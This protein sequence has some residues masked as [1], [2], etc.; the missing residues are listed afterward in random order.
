MFVIY[1][2]LLNQIEL[3]VMF[4]NLINY[5]DNILQKF[6]AEELEKIAENCFTSKTKNY[7]LLAKITPF[8]GCGQICPLLHAVSI[9]EVKAIEVMIDNYR[10]DLIVALREYDVLGHLWFSSNIEKPKD[11]KTEQ[12]DNLYNLTYMISDYEINS[13]RNIKRS[14][15]TTDE[16]LLQINQTRDF[17]DNSFQII[18]EIDK[19]SSKIKQSD[20]TSHVDMTIE[21]KKSK[22]AKV[23][24]ILFKYTKEI[25]QKDLENYAKVASLAEFN[26]LILERQVDLSKMSLKLPLYDILTQEPLLKG[27]NYNSVEDILLMHSYS[28]NKTQAEIRKVYSNLLNV[29][30]VASDIMHFTALNLLKGDDLKIVFDSPIPGAYAPMENI[31]MI[32][33][34]NGKFT[35]ESIVIHELGHYAVSGLYPYSNMKPFDVTKL[36]LEETTQDDVYGYHLNVKSAEKD[37]FFEEA[38]NDIDKFLKYE[39]AAKKVFIKAGELLGLNAKSFEPY[40]LSKDFILHFKDNSPIDLFMLK[41]EEQFGLENDSL[42]RKIVIYESY[43]SHVEK[44]EEDNTCPMPSFVHYATLL[45]DDATCSFAIE[46]YIKNALNYEEMKGLV[47]SQYIPHLVNRGTLNFQVRHR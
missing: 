18:D 46:N 42:S 38:H 16:K 7:E 24:K 35:T 14:N 41:L 34:M 20:V 29:S 10:D 6:N 39:Q 9:L 12:L 22:I 33:K 21:E 30:K 40:V 25:T 45:R 44:G 5:P 32:G 3:E 1:F 37:T 15:S 47:V 23:A 17:R 27:M 2:L 8:F 26:M 4:T 11:I 19:L 36:N 28:Q 43:I 13:A 31:I